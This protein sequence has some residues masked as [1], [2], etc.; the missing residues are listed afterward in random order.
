MTTV[1]TRASRAA[2]S[3]DV[4][5]SIVGAA[6]WVCRDR[7]EHLFWHYLALPVSTPFFTGV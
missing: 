7:S 6:G 1:E 3:A 5:E 4:E 2:G